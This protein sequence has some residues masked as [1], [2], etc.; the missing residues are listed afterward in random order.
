MKKIFFLILLILTPAVFAQSAFT[1]GW[2]P[3]IEYKGNGTV[4]IVK[5][6]IDTTDQLNSTAFS[7]LGYDKV[8]LATYPLTAGVKLSGTSTATRKVH[9]FIQGSYDGTNWANVDTISNADS[10]NTLIMK[11]A[12]N[13]NGYRTPYYR[14]AVVGA[15]TA[16]DL[17]TFD[18]RVYAYRRD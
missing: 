2:S 11:T 15:T 18:I 10:A 12:L 7:L 9:C 6:T 17:T 5:G 14:I 8:D 13:L 16:N 4:V 1:T 3:K